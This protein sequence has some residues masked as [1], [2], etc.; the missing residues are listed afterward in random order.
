MPYG[1]GSYDLNEDGTITSAEWDQASAQSPQSP[2]ASGDD[3]D[4]GKIMDFFGQITSAF[5]DSGFEFTPEMLESF[6][7]ILPAMGMY[8]EF[9]KADYQ[10]DALDFMREELGLKGQEIEL[11]REQ[12]AF[13]SGPAWDWYKNEFFP[14]S[15]ENQRLEWD[16]QRQLM[17]G[18]VTQSG[19]ETKQARERTMQALQGTLQ[20]KQSTR[21]A[22]IAS[23]VARLNALAQIG[24]QNATRRL[25]D[26]RQV[27]GSGFTY[28]YGR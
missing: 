20:S 5:G 1:F 26:G 16:T 22:E 27:R 15:M 21:Q 17:E 12:F 13:E 24:P 2:Q 11:A 18:Q 23:E 19:E 14:M 28:G 9:S 10:Q 8:S 7:V 6:G 25:E 3:F 4:I